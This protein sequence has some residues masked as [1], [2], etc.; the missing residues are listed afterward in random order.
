MRVV[1]VHDERKFDEMNT[2]NVPRE[3]GAAYPSSLTDLSA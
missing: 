3:G 1:I 2:S